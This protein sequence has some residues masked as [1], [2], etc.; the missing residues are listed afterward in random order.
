MGET[1][2]GLA[3]HGLLAPERRGYMKEE[4]WEFLLEEIANGKVIPIVGPEMVKVQVPGEEGRVQLYRVLAEKLAAEL[5]I[6]LPEELEGF[7]AINH[8]V[9][10][11]RLRGDQD[12]DMIYVK[13][14][15]YLQKEFHFEPNETLKKLA[16][17]SDFRLFVSTTFDDQLF[18]AVT[19]G[20]A[21]ESVMRRYFYPPRGYMVAPDP[22]GTDLPEEMFDIGGERPSVVYNLFGRLGDDGTFAIWDEDVLDWISELQ[23]GCPDRLEGEF[24]SSHLLLL[25][26]TYS[27]WVARFFMR[28]ANRSQLSAVRSRTIV[29]DAPSSHDITLVNFV[30]GVG[31][32]LSV[33]DVHGG[34]GAF[35]ER[36][37]ERWSSNRSAD[38]FGRSTATFTPF[39]NSMS[40]GGVFL[41]Y[42]RPT[43][44][45]IVKRL[46]GALD[47]VG[48]ESWFDRSPRSLE[49]G[50]DWQM[51]ILDNIRKCEL[52]VP[53]LST[54][55]LGRRNGFFY[56]EWDF[57][58]DLAREKR[59][60][61]SVHRPGQCR[62][63]RSRR[64][65]EKLPAFRRPESDLG[66][67]YG[68]EL[69]APLRG[70]DREDPRALRGIGSG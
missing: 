50:D 15:K 3:R 30:K 34:I 65:S 6:E 45:E 33:I 4:D 20:R 16:E 58:S 14:R 1:Q 23:S 70:G 55:A 32:K 26:T 63:R 51:Q 59:P 10:S 13:L 18:K 31:G 66:V 67:R 54:G 41:S 2:S 29:A 53:V 56:K 48:I 22:A 69:P 42:S 64:G 28:M 39:G 46:K 9:M 25:G 38:V 37:Y 61:P 60:E 52:F 47:A 43:D 36:L 21:G 62:S 19:Q 12:I 11:R 5:K 17:I 24:R 27:D 49:Y 40:K 44:S 68:F 57:A 35:V 7:S 8:I